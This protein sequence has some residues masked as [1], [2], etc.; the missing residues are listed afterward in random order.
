MDVQFVCLHHGNSFGHSNTSLERSEKGNEL[1]VVT[2]FTSASVF[3]PELQARSVRPERRFL[4]TTFAKDSRMGCFPL[5][6]LLPISLGLA[7]SP[8]SGLVSPYSF[9]NALTSTRLRTASLS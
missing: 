3:P 6:A 1:A 4:A 9:A 7:R 2:K 5:L 8:L